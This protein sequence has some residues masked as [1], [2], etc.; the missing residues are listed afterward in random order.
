VSHIRIRAL[1]N[2]ANYYS[3]LLFFCSHVA[4]VIAD[5]LI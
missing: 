1:K 4:V 3:D 5:H 2:H